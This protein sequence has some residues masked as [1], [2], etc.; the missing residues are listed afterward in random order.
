MTHLGV[1]GAVRQRQQQQQ[2]QQQQLQLQRLN[3]GVSPLRFASV[4]MTHHFFLGGG[5]IERVQK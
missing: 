3:T 5:G 4:E 2:Q 1:V